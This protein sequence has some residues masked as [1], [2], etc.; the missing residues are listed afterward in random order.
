MVCGYLGMAKQTSR[1]LSKGQWEETVFVLPGL[2]INAAAR[3]VHFSTLLKNLCPEGL[4]SWG[5]TENQLSFTA[6]EAGD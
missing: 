5:L 2:Y 1:G 3:G 4:L 6:V